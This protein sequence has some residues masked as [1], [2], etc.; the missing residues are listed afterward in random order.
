[1]H[2]ATINTCKYVCDQPQHQLFGYPLEELIAVRYLNETVNIFS[3]YYS[4]VVLY[5]SNWWSH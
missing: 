3:L 2:G 4:A 5:S 1:M